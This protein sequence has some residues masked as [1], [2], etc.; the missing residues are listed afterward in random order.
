MGSSVKHKTFSS[1][2]HKV[3][4][5]HQIDYMPAAPG[6]RTIELCHDE[7]ILRPV[8]CWRLLSV[9]VP[10]EEHFTYPQPVSPEGAEANAVLYPDGTI[11]EYDAIWGSLD[12]WKKD[13]LEYQRAKAEA[14]AEAKLRAEAEKARKFD[15]IKARIQPS[16]P[17]APSAKG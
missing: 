13:E 14:R 5:Y 11:H 16:A 15:S 2:G 3:K 7:V 4:E 1:K 12:D 6:L 17:S 8:I 9:L 10:E